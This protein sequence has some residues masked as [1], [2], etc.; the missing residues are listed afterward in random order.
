MSQNQATVLIEITKIIGSAYPPHQHHWSSAYQQ[1]TTGYQPWMQPTCKIYSCEDQIRE[2]ASER[3]S[4]NRDYKKLVAVAYLPPPAPPDPSAYLSAPPPAG[5]ATKDGQ[6]HLQNPVP[7]ETKS[8]GDD[9][10]KR[11]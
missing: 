1:P 2:M 8:R 9:F 6:T 5:Y 11:W 3:M 10:W 4:T 7:V